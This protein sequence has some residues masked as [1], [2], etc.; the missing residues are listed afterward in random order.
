[1]NNNLSTTDDT[2]TSSSVTSDCKEGSQALYELHTQNDTPNE[3]TIC[4]VEPFQTAAPTPTT[5][6]N[7]KKLENDTEL[8]QHAKQIERARRSEKDE[9]DIEILRKRLEWN[10][11]DDDTD[12]RTTVKA[13]GPFTSL[14][15]KRLLRA[16]YPNQEKFCKDFLHLFDTLSP[17]MSEKGESIISF[18][19][20]VIG[21]NIRAYVTSVVALLSE[22]H[23][24]DMKRYSYFADGVQTGIIAMTS[25]DR[26]Q[27]IQWKNIQSNKKKEF[28]K[29]HQTQ[30]EDLRHKMRKFEKKSQAVRKNTKKK[31]GRK[32]K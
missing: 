31:K 25:C 20:S 2:S 19:E 15:I 12:N 23:Q 22:G 10:P 26:S 14:T 16:V 32:K 27:V 8:I 9:R 4:P 11:Q 28:D 3:A 30:N 24:I 6:E 7:D 13:Q 5:L 29:W 1:M 21:I 18:L 17:L